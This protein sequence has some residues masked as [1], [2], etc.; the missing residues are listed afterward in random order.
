MILTPLFYRKFISEF[1]LVCQKNHY[2]I[3][4]N[5]KV[6]N[7]VFED[8]V[9]KLTGRVSN[10]MNLQYHGF[11]PHTLMNNSTSL[12]KQHNEFQEYD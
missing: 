10:F 1:I 7:I 4:P 12:C 8:H 2:F 6:V 3:Q 5:Y 11:T 9:K